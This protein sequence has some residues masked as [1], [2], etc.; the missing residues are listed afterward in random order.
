MPFQN[1]WKRQ[2]KPVDLIS[3]WHLHVIFLLHSSSATIIVAERFWHLADNNSNKG[4]LNRRSLVQDAWLENDVHQILR[5]FRAYSP[6]SKM[7]KGKSWVFTVFTSKS[8]FFRFATFSHRF[9]SFSGPYIWWRLMVDRGQGRDVRHQPVQD[10]G[11][12]GLG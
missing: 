10:T 3:V 7:S 8:L 5:V 4:D 2:V 1:R 9:R 6:W 11:L 12:Q